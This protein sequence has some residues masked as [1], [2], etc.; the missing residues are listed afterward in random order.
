MGLPKPEP[1]TNYW[2]KKVARIVTQKSPL[3]GLLI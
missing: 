1:I 3:S 2:R